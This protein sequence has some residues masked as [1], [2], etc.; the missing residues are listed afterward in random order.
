MDEPR[1]RA[2][3]AADVPAIAEIADEAYRHYIARI[4]KLPRPMLDDYAARVSE[5]VVWLLEE[6]AA[7]AAIVVLCPR[8]TICSSIISLSL[9]LARDWGWASGFSHSRRPRQ[10]SEGVR[11]S[12]STR[13]KRWWRISAST[14][15]SVMR[16]RDAAPRPA[17]IASLC[18]SNFAGDQSVKRTNL[19]SSQRVGA[20]GHLDNRIR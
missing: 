13:I 20:S 17:T 10:C 4:G 1:I 11:K 12:G 2:A 15:Q 6:G 19:G 18:A 5:G 8:R 14:L 16:R 9:P 7:I 3:T